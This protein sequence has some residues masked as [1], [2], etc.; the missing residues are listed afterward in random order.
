M[1]SN[2]LTS[3]GI[4]SVTAP[5]GGFWADDEKHLP[6]LLTEKMA[7]LLKQLSTLGGRAMRKGALYYY[8]MGWLHNGDGKV[9]GMF[10]L[11]YS[12]EKMHVCL[13]RGSKYIWF[14]ELNKEEIVGKI[15]TDL[16][17]ELLGF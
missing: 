3:A 7:P 10:A 13:L 16:F 17:N 1:S 14:F 12:K 8:K 9:D 4:R 2:C 6:T 15:T 11:S 5:F